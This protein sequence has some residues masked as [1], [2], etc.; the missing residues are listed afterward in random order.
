VCW[1]TLVAFVFVSLLAV[2]QARS[3]SSSLGGSWRGGGTVTYSSGH[4][5]R[6]RCSAHYSGGSGSQISV[7]ATCATPS[8]SVSQSARQARTATPEPSSTLNLTSPAVFTS[9]GMETARASRSG[10]EA[11]L[12]RLHSDTDQRIAAATK[13]RQIGL[14]ALTLFAG[15]VSIRFDPWP[16]ASFALN[17]TS[18]ALPTSSQPQ[19]FGLT[20]PRATADAQAA[21]V[22]GY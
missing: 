12:L 22:T 7:S 16:C 20:L 10:A 14:K 21:P 4:R 11:G 2:P 19:A 18:F 9:S 6:A 13:S 17:K 15:W 3:E 8:G 5:E 1:K